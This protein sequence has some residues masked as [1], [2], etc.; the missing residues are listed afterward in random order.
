MPTFRTINISLLRDD[1][2][3]TARSLGANAY[4]LQQS[5][6]NKVVPIPSNNTATNPTAPI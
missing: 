3:D 6:H 2:R 4:A 1:H 5:S